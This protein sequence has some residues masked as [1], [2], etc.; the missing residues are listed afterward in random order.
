MTTEKE[1]GEALKRG[2][3]T[4]EVELDLARKVLVALKLMQKV[5]GIHTKKKEL[6][7]FI[8]EN[9]TVAWHPKVVDQCDEY[10]YEDSEEG[11][12]F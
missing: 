11:D 8:F 10:P 2:D 7:K 9:V 1:L 4:I 12:L 3:S 5:Y 6:E